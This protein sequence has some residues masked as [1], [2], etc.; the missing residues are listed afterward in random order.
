LISKLSELP[1][2]PSEILAIEDPLDALL[3]DIAFLGESQNLETIP[4]SVK[5]KIRLHRKKLGI[6]DYTV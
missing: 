2:R 5:D 4:F 1:H 6:P 3:T